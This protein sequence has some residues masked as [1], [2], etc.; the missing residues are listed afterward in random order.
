[1]SSTPVSEKFYSSRF[2][3]T[4]QN[5][6]L[7]HPEKAVGIYVGLKEYGLAG[8]TEMRMYGNAVGVNDAAAAE[9]LKKAREYYEIQLDAHV[10]EGAFRSAGRVALKM[11]DKER[12]LKLFVDGFWFEDASAIASQLGRFDEA[13]AYAEKAKISRVT[14]MDAAG[15]FEHSVKRAKR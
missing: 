1:M 5:D 10:K 9:H 2:E 3:A 8:D 4:R 13:C 11:D 7:H 14:L 12:A 6:V 15:C